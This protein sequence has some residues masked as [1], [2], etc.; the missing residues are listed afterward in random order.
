[1]KKRRKRYR[2]EGFFLVQGVPKEFLDKGPMDNFQK[3]KFALLVHFDSKQYPQVEV[4]DSSALPQKDWANLFLKQFCLQLGL[5]PKRYIK[6]KKTPSEH[7]LLGGV[8][9][10][11][12]ALQK[13]AREVGLDWF[14]AVIRKKSSQ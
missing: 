2:P 1:M 14:L 5:S 6:H 12:L 7:A 8:N 3:K 11:N 10:I 9:L 13:G 4:F